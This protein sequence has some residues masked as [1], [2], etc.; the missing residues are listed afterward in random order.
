MEPDLIQ[1]LKTY[2][3][4]QCSRQKTAAALFTH[5][6]TVI[7]R[8]RKIGKLKGLDMTQ[9]S[10]L[11]H[12]IHREPLSYEPGLWS[13]IFPLGMYAVAGVYLGRPAHLPIVAAIGQAELWLAVAAFLAT[14]A[15]MLW[16]LWTTL[17][18]SRQR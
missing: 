15:G 12:V 2:A 14:F 4:M 13:V 6:Q 7:Y 17:V 9:T 1:T 16:H 5:R 3:D 10:A 18:R 11:R 8:I